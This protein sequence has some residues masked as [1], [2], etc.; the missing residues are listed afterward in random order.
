[1]LFKIICTYFPPRRYEESA[2]LS[3]PHTLYEAAALPVRHLN[4]VH[5]GRFLAGQRPAPFL[6]RL[7][8][9]LPPPAD[10]IL[11]PRRATSCLIP[12]QNG[13]SFFSRP[14]NVPEFLGRPEPVAFA[15]AQTQTAEEEDVDYNKSNHEILIAAQVKLLGQLLLFFI[16]SLK[17][18]INAI[19][20][21]RFC[22]V[23]SVCCVSILLRS[24]RWRSR[25]Q[26]QQTSRASTSNLV[27][28]SLGQNQSCQ[29]M[30]PP[31]PP[32]RQPTKFRTVCT[33]APA[34]LFGGASLQTKLH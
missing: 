16:T 7:L 20:D 3:G 14:A 13:H 8:V 12:P 5:V 1:M 26:D 10:H 29:S 4:L 21:I 2:R 6:Q 9:L 28:C 32:P 11:A 17:Q 22:P 33:Q 25:C 31:P 23:S 34:G 27:H 30:I 15:A 24:L 19:F 18:H